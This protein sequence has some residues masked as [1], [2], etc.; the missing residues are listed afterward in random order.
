MERRNTIT[1][2]EER[3]ADLEALFDEM[4]MCFND[5]EDPQSYARQLLQGPFVRPFFQ[6]YQRDYLDGREHLEEITQP[7]ELARLCDEWDVFEH[8]A[9]KEDAAP[10][11]SSW[12]VKQHTARFIIRVLHFSWRNGGRWK[13]GSWKY[14]RTYDIHGESDIEFFEVWGVLRYLQVEWE[15]ANLVHWDVGH[16][17]AWDTAS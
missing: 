12:S 17:R 4:L 15:A 14:D 11:K 5:I 3:Q 16:L 2:P 13:R 8:P 6:E 1:I 10:D 9:Y 7:G